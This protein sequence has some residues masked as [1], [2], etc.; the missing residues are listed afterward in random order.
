MRATEFIEAS[1]KGNLGMMEMMKFFKIATPEEK[2][3]MKRLLAQGDQDS[4]WELLQQVTDTELVNELFKPGKTNWEWARLGRDEVSA[5]FKVGDREY[6]W[7]AFTGSNPTKWE[8]QFRLIRKPD[9]DPDELDLFGK[10]DTGNSAE[11]MSTAVD[12]TRAF[13]K[14]YG[15]DRVEEITFNAKEDSRIGLYAKMIK[16][17]LPGW[18]LYSKKDP[19]DGMIFSLT[20]RRAYDKPEN[21]INELFEPDSGYKLEWD[22]QFGPKE[23][24]ARAYDRQGQYID[25]NFV[26]VRDNVTDIEFSKMDN[27]DLTG[28]GDE[29]AIFATVVTAIRR[30]LKGYQP[31]IIVFS[32]KG[33]GRGGLYQKMINRLAGQF[34]YQQFDTSKLSPQGQAQLGA[35]GTNVFV[36]RKKTQPV[37]QESGVSGAGG[38]SFKWNGDAPYRHLV[39]KDIDEDMTRR[40]FLGAL[41]ALGATAAA[42]AQAATGLKPPKEYNLLGNNANNEIAVHKTALGSGLKG[43][44]LA[45]FLG[46]MKHESWNFERLKEKPMGKDYFE[47]RYGVKYAPKTAKI[48]GNKAPGDGQKYYGRGFI[49]LTGRDNYRMAGQALGIDLLN[50]PELA[51][52]PD[53]AA[54]IAVWYWKTR[55]KPIVT[56]FADTTA[57]TKAINPAMRG[58]E[59]RHANFKDYMRII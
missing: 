22:D 38:D 31:K 30:Y 56:N 49:Q 44:E 13:L 19:V 5:F 21:K 16:R 41:G 1:Y 29:M 36:L 43:P 24:H 10:T 17:L 52:K 11:V 12:I 57:V 15:L 48:L 32:G 33:E 37:T 50:H 4:A 23:I 7:Q 28:K 53:I 35:T 27:F 6:L 3:L 40:G 42:G 20:D 8:I 54:K 58:L 55:V 46:Q 25:I 59:D 51:A 18:D 34:G 26:P 45:Q 47:K 2:E 39:E 14:E 9:V